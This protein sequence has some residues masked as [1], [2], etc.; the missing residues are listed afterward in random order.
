MEG[1]GSIILEHFQARLN[2]GEWHRVHLSVESRLA[3][4]LVDNFT[5]S[6]SL[7]TPIRTGGRGGGGGMGIY[8]SKSGGWGGRN[9]KDFFQEF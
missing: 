4:L 5:Q 9:N 7:H 6:A 1:G 2:D 8:S 3:V